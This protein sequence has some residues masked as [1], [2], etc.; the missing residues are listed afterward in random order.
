MQ[1]NKYAGIDLHQSTCVIEVQNQAGQVLSRS[2][3]KTEAE[4][5]RDFFRG[6]GGTIHITFEVGTQSAWLYEILKPVVTSCTVC[7]VRKHKKRGNKSDRIDAHKLS[8]L[9]RLG[10]LSQ[11]HQGDRNTRKLRD[12]AHGYLA[13]VSDT[14]RVM[15]R[16]KALYRSWGIRCEGRDVY[17]KRNREEWI[18]KFPIRES[19]M[20]AGLYYGQLDL[21]KEQRRE[22]KKIFLKEARRYPVQKI[23]RKIPGFGPIRSAFAI[24]VIGTPHRFRTK[25]QLWSYSGLS[26]VMQTSSDYEEI[27]GRIIRKHRRASTRGLTQDYNRI[28]KMV[29]KGAA[30]EAIRKDP[31]RTLYKIKVA[32]GIRP[33]MAILSISRRIASIALVLW[34]RGEKFDVTKLISN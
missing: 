25:R 4:A 20:R 28:L 10:E 15:N 33:E 18:S 31:M 21:L 17:Y 12:L 30:K 29:F 5:L 7:D 32:N 8:T 19:G 14:V 27:K 24:A 16:I 23:L 11:V 6:M 22:T 13:T 1:E 34:K 9:L 2:I 26:V 3:I